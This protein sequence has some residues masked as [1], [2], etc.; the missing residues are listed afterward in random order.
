MFRSWALFGVKMQLHKIKEYSSCIGQRFCHSA[1]LKRDFIVAA[2]LH[3]IVNCDLDFGSRIRLLSLKYRKC[4]VDCFDDKNGTITQTGN[5]QAQQKLQNI[6][7]NHFLP[8]CMVSTLSRKILI[9]QFKHRAGQR[10]FELFSS[11]QQPSAFLNLIY[12]VELFALTARFSQTVCCAALR[13]AGVPR[14]F[15]MH[16]IHNVHPSYLWVLKK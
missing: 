8:P 14:G 12:S 10:G 3:N 1:C 4:A 7:Q 11:H 2:I 6:T 16:I 5:K 9:K 13:A 15:K